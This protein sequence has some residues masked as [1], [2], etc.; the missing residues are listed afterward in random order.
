M[1]KRNTPR[2][3][4]YCRVATESQLSIDAQKARLTRFTLSKGYSQITCYEDNGASGL[5]F[6]RPGFRRMEADI[7]AGKID[8]IVVKDASKVGREL[9]QTTHW[10]NNLIENGKEFVTADTPDAPILR[11]E[12]L[13]QAIRESC[14]QRAANGYKRK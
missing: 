7:Q 13:E 10:I 14:K 1:D 6:D 4:I 11:L 9:L 5:T 12:S 3:A 8:V 2:V